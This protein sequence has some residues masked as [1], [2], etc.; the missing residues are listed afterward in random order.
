MIQGESFSIQ[1]ITTY[2]AVTW[3]K[4]SKTWALYTIRTLSLTLSFAYHPQLS[5]QIVEIVLLQH[6][7]ATTEATVETGCPL[8]SAARTKTTRMANYYRMQL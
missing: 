6:V 7:A 4:C 5:G 3:Q 1:T 2:V 8:H